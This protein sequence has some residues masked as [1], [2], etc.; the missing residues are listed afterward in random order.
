MRCGIR[1]AVFVFAVAPSIHAQR[2]TGRAVLEG[3][4]RDSATGKA[5]TRAHACVL[6]DS[7]N[8]MFYSICAPV[9][10]STAAYRLDSL[11]AGRLPVSVS[12]GTVRPFAHALGSDSIM[13]SDSAAVQRNWVVGTAG[14]DPRPLRRV[15]GIFRG[16]Y[17]P[18]FESSEFVPCV[19]DAWFLQS[20]S[21]RSKPYDERRAWAYLGRRSVPDNFKWPRAPED[22]FGYRRYYVQWR[23]TVV[24]PGHYGH[25]GVSPFEIHV[26]SVLTLR[27]PRRGDCRSVTYGGR[28]RLVQA[29]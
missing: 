24:G 26:D 7:G 15:S 11:P 6:L 2:P 20:D 10:T 27:A 25:M 13:F 22:D 21:L 18:G 5:V 17:T 28:D 4:V 1:W 16:Y 19:E 29:V 12:C 14:C 23:G 8:S 9:D 3:T